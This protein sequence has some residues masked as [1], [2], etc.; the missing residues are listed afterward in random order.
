MLKNLYT[1]FLSKIHSLFT[2]IFGDFS[3]Q[4][5]AWIGQAKLKA[6]THPKQFWQGVTVIAVLCLLSLLSYHWYHH[7]PQPQQIIAQITAPHITPNEK[8]LV[9]DNL[10]IEFGVV[11]DGTL[12]TRSAAPLNAIGKPI[13]QG[14][15]LTPQV[16][17]T[18]SWETDSHLIFIPDKDWPAGQ[19]YTVE[20]D[21]D[22]FAANASPASLKKHF[23]YPAF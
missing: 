13:K 2:A 19:T 22:F 1:R 6:K 16:S 21:R 11:V 7:R 3:W 9:P 15:K 10:N 4:A 17:G 5:P 12:N 18:W 14:V 8:S 20:F 23:C